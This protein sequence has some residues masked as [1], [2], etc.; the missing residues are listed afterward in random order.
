MGV[1]DR[2]RNRE[3]SVKDLTIS[4]TDAEIE[5]IKSLWPT[6]ERFRLF[7]PNNVLAVVEKIEQAIGELK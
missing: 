3:D 1:N 5:S 4:V 2:P 6:L 7:I